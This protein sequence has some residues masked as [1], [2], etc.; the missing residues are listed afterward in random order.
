LATKRRIKGK[1]GDIP[2]DFEAFVSA[3]MA[4]GRPPKITK[5]KKQKKKRATTKK[6]SR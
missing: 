5:P 1:G 4:T 3:A 2:L 6:S